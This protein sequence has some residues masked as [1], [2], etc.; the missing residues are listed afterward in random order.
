MNRFLLASVFAILLLPQPAATQEFTGQWLDIG[1]YANQ[2]L[3][4][5]VTAKDGMLYP[6]LLRHSGHLYMQTFWLGVKDW[7]NP[8][9][10]QYPYYV[11]QIGWYGQDAGVVFPIQNKLIGR[12]EDTMVIV[13]GLQS[14]ERDTALDEIDPDLPADRM[15]HNI[16]NTSLGITA[17]RKIYAYAHPY[18]DNY[19]LIEYTYC[20]TGNTDRDENIELA[21]QIL[22]D[23][24][25]FRVHRWRG[26]EQ[27]AWNGSGDA[28][29][30]WGG[31]SMHDTVGDGHD[32]YPVDFTAQYMWMGRD[33]NG[34]FYDGHAYSNLGAALMSLSPMGARMV[35]EGDTVGRLAGPTMVGRSTIHADLSPTNNAYD[36]GQPSTMSFIHNQ[37]D[38]FTGDAG[39]EDIYELG[40]L[41]FENPDRNPG[42]TTCF[43]RAYP[44]YADRIESGGE[45]WNPTNHAAFGS[46]SGY[47]ATT[48][49]GPYEMAPGECVNIVVSEGVAG[50][51]FD[52]ATK[53]GRMY[54]R[55][56]PD[57]DARIIEHDADGNG[58]I[59]FTPFDYDQVFVGTEAQ[60]KNQWVM[61][62][63]DSLFQMFYRARDL[64]EA[65]NGMTRYPIAEPPRPPVRFSVRGRP[66]RIDLAWTPAPDG[67]YVH[68]WEIYRTEN[69]VDNLYVNGCLED[70]SI[71]CGYERIVS[72]P[73]SVT[74]YPDMDVQPG[75][76]YY[77][78]IQGVGL[79]QPEDPTAINGTPYGQ[80]L[81]SGR[82]LTQTYDPVSLFSST[83]VAEE[84]VP[85]RFSL[86]GNYPN[87]FNPQTTIR[88][89]LPEAADVELV[90][91]DVLGREVAV[92]VSEQQAAGKYEQ[93]FS[94]ADLPSGLY[95]YVL[96]A[97]DNRAAGKMIVVQ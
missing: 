20:N 78:Y 15:I 89:T 50:L 39:H 4:S 77:Y 24:Y 47:S 56:G 97:G 96:Q 5:G 26:N 62:A 35:A 49:Y 32:V 14:F 93:V 76:D 79:P 85:G 64:Y 66:D 91:Y 18:H 83:G 51:S 21:D 11:A 19:H 43:T 54:K 34:L 27:A 36:R 75:T 67:P 63:R 29:Q 6:A 55:S 53:I 70:L 82:Y 58:E 9:G 68:H 42:C 23:V 44:H 37:G 65:S 92:L 90:V 71:E 60:T 7:T 17:D 16:F 81:R 41:T 38:F 73:A 84:T 13:D 95:V 3:D 80:P 2:Y 22:N 86:E 33:H 28:R 10:R 57:R 30:W 74:S 69:W 87:P 1:A 40:I 61:S 48:G 94:A 72:L 59:N 88:Y 12:Y 25:F 45:F 31:F 8:E 52:A 46:Q